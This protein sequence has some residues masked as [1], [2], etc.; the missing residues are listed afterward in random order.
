ERPAW[1]FDLARAEDAS[2]S[3][4]QDSLISAR[5]VRQEIATKD[6]IQNAFDGITYQKG[7]TV[8]GMFEQFVGAEPFRKGVQTYLSRHAMKNAT[9]AEFLADLSEGAGRDVRA[10]FSTF[11]DQP[12]VPLVTATV[13]CE[14]GAAKLALA[15]ERYLPIGSSGDPRASTWQI[16][17]CARW[18]KGR[19]TGE[20]CTLLAGP[21][22]ELAL[23]TKGCPDWVLPKSK[24]LGYYRVNYP[25]KDV[26]ALLKRDKSLSLVE[27][28]GVIHDGRALVAA[29][30]LPL[31]DML[32]RLPDLARAPEPELLRAGLGV[33]L[34]TRVPLELRPNEARFLDRAIGARAKAYGWHSRPSDTPEERLLRPMLLSAAADRGENA[35]LVAEAQRLAA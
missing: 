24:S 31:G 27:R 1:K 35:A 11:L 33:P 30:K 22:G 26:D 32:A 18:G 16:P 9:S 8:I 14:G 21:R 3:M 23:P 10:A 6:D 17:V 20:A 15:Q 13:A 7:A 4:G 34:S 28:V 29:G 12:G 19:E 25:A 2:W 5:K